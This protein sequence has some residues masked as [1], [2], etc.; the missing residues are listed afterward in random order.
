M[1]CMSASETWLPVVGF[2]TCYEVSD[3]GRV[4]SLDRYVPAGQGRTRI[5]RGRVMSPYVGDHYAKVQLKVGGVGTTKYV[6][7]LVAQSFLGPRPD[8]FEVCHCNGDRSDNRAT[9]LRYD[10]HSANQ[11]DQVA[12]GIHA[13]ARRTHCNHGHELTSD[14]VYNESG[15]RRCIACDRERGARRRAAKREAEGRVLR[16]ELTHCKNGHEFDGHNGRQ[17]TCST[18]QREYQ[19]KYRQR[20]LQQ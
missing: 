6:H 2:E 12:H 8:G 11:L 10:T 19:H 14:N 1:G 5:A 16:S 15:R 17:K 7:A 4:R 18:C 9:N 3:L 13:E 20:R